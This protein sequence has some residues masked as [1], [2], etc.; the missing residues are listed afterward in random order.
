MPSPRPL[1][2]NAVARAEQV[3]GR[4]AIAANDAQMHRR[5]FS[6][7]AEE[8]GQRENVV[9]AVMGHAKEGMTFGL[10]S[11]AQLVELKRE[12]VESVRLPE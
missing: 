5:W 12:C 10:Y 4:T 11:K 8:A 6:T 9:A 3:D 2:R 1:P 7:K